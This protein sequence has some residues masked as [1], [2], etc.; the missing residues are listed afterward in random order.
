[1]AEEPALKLDGVSLNLQGRQVLRNFSL[2]LSSGEKVLLQGASGSGKTTILRLL[3]GFVRPDEGS[4]EIHG[5]TLSGQTVWQL[6]TQVAYVPQEPELGEGT[7]EEY[8]EHPFSY[9]ANAELRQNL[10]RTDELFRQFKLDPALKTQAISTLSGGER[11]RLALICAV[12]LQRST[13]LLDEASSALDKEAKASVVDFFKQQPELT[14][15]A[16]SHDQ[17][18]ASFADRVVNLSK[19]NADA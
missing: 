18:W 19:E 1:M 14:V 7:V 5:Q 9:H 2:E 6:R 3:L 12:L 10:D 15:L 13:I 11:Q 4:I 17:E 16:V 8:L